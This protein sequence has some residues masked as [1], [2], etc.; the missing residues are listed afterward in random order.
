MVW[1]DVVHG[2]LFLFLLF[3]LAVLGS[4]KTVFSKQRNY[5]IACFYHFKTIIW[6]FIVN[7]FVID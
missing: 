4:I 7:I 1:C 5:F 2:S 6:I 3:V